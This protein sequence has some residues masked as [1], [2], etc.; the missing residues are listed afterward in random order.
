MRVVRDIHIGTEVTNMQCYA[1]L[2]MQGVNYCHVCCG[3]SA[4]SRHYFFDSRP[5]G[6]LKC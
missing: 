4:G 2:Y 6:D 3:S 1:A 5:T